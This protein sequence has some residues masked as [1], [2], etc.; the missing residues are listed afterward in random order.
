V[1]NAIADALAPLGVWPSAL[2]VGP[3]SIVGLFS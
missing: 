1:A 2:P 3:A